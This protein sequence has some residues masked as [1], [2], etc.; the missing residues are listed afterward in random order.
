MDRFEGRCWLDWWANSSTL[1]DSV[2]VAVVIAAAT[3]GWEAN[4][5]LVSDSDEDREA[6]AFLCELDP[7]FALRFEDESVVAVT[8]HPT[9]AHRRFRLTEYTGP[10]QRS[11][12]NRIAL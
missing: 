8:V 12:V 2:E 9:D 4:G 7:V 10:V 1:L 3:G 11:V 5:R 6:F